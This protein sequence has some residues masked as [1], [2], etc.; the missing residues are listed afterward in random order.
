MELEARVLNLAC[1]TYTSDLAQL[2]QEAIGSFKRRPG[3]DDLTRLH[4]VTVTQLGFET[5]GQALASHPQKAWY[6][7]HSDHIELR[8]QLRLHLKRYLQERLVHDG[9]AANA[10]QDDHFAGDLGL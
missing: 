9:Y 7:L 4:R 2:L 10:V 5:L 1:M 6:V 8:W 3:L